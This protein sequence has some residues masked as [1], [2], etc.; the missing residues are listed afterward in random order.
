MSE[1]DGLKVTGE[2]TI[3]WCAATP[4]NETTDDDG[5]PYVPEAK[6]GRVD[7]RAPR[8]RAYDDPDVQALRARLR[9]HN[10]MRGV[11]I[12]EPHEVERA[13]RIFFRDGFVVVNNLLDP[14]R[15]AIWRD[16]SAR[17]LKL[18]L[19]NKGEGGR[20]YI[21]ESGRLPHRYSYGTASASRELLHEPAWASM[22]DLPT[23]TP[24]LEKIFGTKDYFVRGAGGDLCL[25]GAIEYQGLHADTRDDFTISDERRKQAE[26]VGIKLRNIPGTD[27]LDPA[28]VELIL[29]RTPP[30]VTINF[31]MSD[32]TWEN[33][34]IRQ[35]PGTQGRVPTPPLLADEPEWMRL[36]TLVG[37]K[38]GAGVFRDNRAWH[39]A[40]PNLSR[41]IRAMPNVEYHAPWVDPAKYWKSMPHEIWETLSPHAQHISR[42]VKEV[43]GV[44]PAGAGVMHPLSAKRRE[45]KE[46]V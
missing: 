11:E 39:G 31:L 26:R 8:A 24:I 43:P 45:A 32:F 7:P 33:G 36:S 20:K 22:I 37:A 23:T 38:A 12:V 28:T 41:E 16:A 13:A 15:L 27:E 3:G 21:T 29:E 40:T 30:H 46:R 35:I 9:E 34:P 25:P 5:N 14:E 44:W 17:V 6:S 4:P 10:G 19:E 42:H 1:L 2:T 18:I